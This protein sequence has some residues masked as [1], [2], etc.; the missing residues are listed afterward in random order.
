M[1]VIDWDQYPEPWRSLGKEFAADPT[2]RRDGETVTPPPEA[3]PLR[4]LRSPRRYYRR[5]RLANETIAA[6]L[7][8]Y[9]AT[10]T[11]RAAAQLLGITPAGVGHRIRCY[12]HATGVRIRLRR[13]RKS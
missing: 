11:Q 13:S 10:G 7:K 4:E 5:Q 12:E 1:T 3:M 8:A 9:R 6:T 2:Q